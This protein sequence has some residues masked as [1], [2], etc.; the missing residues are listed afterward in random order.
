MDTEE[1]PFIRVHNFVENVYRRRNNVGS[2]DFDNNV[3]QT[4][5]H[6]QAK[7]LLLRLDIALI[8][9]FLSLYRRANSATKKSEVTLNLQNN[10]VECQSLIKTAEESKRIPQQVEGYIFMAQLYAT[11]LPS[12]SETKQA[13]NHRICGKE[14]IDTARRLCRAYPGQ[15]SGFMEEIEGAEKMLNGSTFYTT[16]T[17]EERM[18]VLSAMARE[19]RGTGHW[20]YCRNGHP[21]T[22]GECGVA[23]E[24]ST[25]PECGAP[26]GGQSHQAVDGVR[27]A[28]DLERNLGQM[29]L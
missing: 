28:D 13:E 4:K 26:V 27:W 25:C 12:C 2:F 15:T 10:R 5:G 11:E 23:M 9:D 17:N 21:F 18:A 29:T 24:L 7:A 19:F 14:A 6:L 3:L 8:A 16:V 20:Y 1:Q 22:I